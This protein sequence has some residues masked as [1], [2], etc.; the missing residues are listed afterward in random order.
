MQNSLCQIQ[1]CLKSLLCQVW[2][3]VHPH[4]ITYRIFNKSFRLTSRLKKNV[5][6]MPCFL[7]CLA[8]KL[9]NACFSQNC[10]TSLPAF[11]QIMPQLSGLI[12]EQYH[13]LWSGLVWF[14]NIVFVWDNLC[15]FWNLVVFRISD[16][17]KIRRSFML[18]TTA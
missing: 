3:C 18:L 12:F 14:K 13:T 11:G 15:W 16:L 10:W 4:V 2:K 6:L 17:T 8:F 1:Y 9:D 7:T 5:S